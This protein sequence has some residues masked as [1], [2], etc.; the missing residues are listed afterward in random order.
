MTEQPYLTYLS[1]TFVRSK[2]FSGAKA[3][4]RSSYCAQVLIELD[5]HIKLSGWRTDGYNQ[6]LFQ[7]RSDYLLSADIGFAQNANATWFDWYF[8]PFAALALIREITTGQKYKNLNVLEAK[9]I[10]IES[11][12]FARFAWD[13]SSLTPKENASKALH[14]IEAAANDLPALD[15]YPEMVAQAHSASLYRDLQACS[16]IVAGRFDEARSLC[17]SIQNGE[18]NSNVLFSHQTTAGQKISRPELILR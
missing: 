11:P 18:V 6:L 12:P 16:M 17:E 10:D 1:P 15:V 8:E 9:R 2:G 4:A 13:D 3:E 7:K 14:E 5:K